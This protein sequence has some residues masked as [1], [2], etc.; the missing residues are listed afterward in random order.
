M[1]APATTKVNVATITAQSGFGTSAYILQHTLHA[2]SPPQGSSRSP[3]P[4]ESFNGDEGT[5]TPDTQ[6][7]KTYILESLLRERRRPMIELCKNLKRQCH[8][9]DHDH[10]QLQEQ[11]GDLVCRHE[12]LEV[13]C[14]VMENQ[15]REMRQDH[16]T[17]K[18]EHGLLNHQYHGLQT[19]YRYLEDE[20]RVQGEKLKRSAEDNLEMCAAYE[21]MEAEHTEE[22]E[23]AKKE[24]ATSK[25]AQLTA[26]AESQVLREMSEA[27]FMEAAQVKKEMELKETLWVE[28][29][30][31]LVKQH[32]QELEKAQEQC[33]KEKLELMQAAQNNRYALEKEVVSLG[34]LADAYRSETQDVAHRHK[35]QIE[36]LTS[37]KMVLIQQVD[38]LQS[39]LEEKMITLPALNNI[40]AQIFNLFSELQTVKKNRAVLLR[41]NEGLLDNAH[42]DQDHINKVWTD[43]RNELAKSSSLASKVA[44]LTAIVKDKHEVICGLI[45]TKEQITF[46]AG[47]ESTTSEIDRKAVYDIRS[48]EFDD[49]ARAH[50]RRN[51]ILDALK[52]KQVEYQALEE[53]TS[54]VENENFRLLCND[55]DHVTRFIEAKQRCEAVEGDLEEVEE[56]RDF[57]RR[58]LEGSADAKGKAIAAFVSK[59]QASNYE[60]RNE[61]WRFQE[62]QEQ[63]EAAVRDKIKKL[64]KRVRS[65]EDEADRCSS[66]YYHE[67]LTT[68]KRLHDRIQELSNQLGLDYYQESSHPYN[69]FVAD[70]NALR[71]AYAIGGYHPDMP[72]EVLE[73]DYF[74]GTIPATVEALRKLRPLGWGPIWELGKVWLTPTVHSYTEEDA[75]ERIQAMNEVERT[76]H[77]QDLGFAVA[78]NHEKLKDLAL[79]DSVQELVAEAK[80]KPVRHALVPSQG[81][82]IQSQFNHAYDNDSLVMRKKRATAT[83]PAPQA[84]D[85]RI[86]SYLKGICADAAKIE[87]EEYYTQEEFES[88]SVSLKDRYLE[89]VAEAN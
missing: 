18:D 66:A 12:H 13:R 21:E 23:S 20:H 58:R 37:E 74:A 16:R 87:E 10:R 52:V 19:R 89:M 7:S 88:L 63:C 72:S 73:P 47:S 4:T 27:K 86:P 54:K 84:D 5:E 14:S 32:K 79:Q 31:D 51:E 56:E 35:V 61:R 24:I 3:S 48:Q 28:K 29:S 46:L 85:S 44:E 76:R 34:L 39:A 59:L 8:T 30:W 57:L 41:D 68:T 36:E 55:D 75:L 45:K 82:T 38:M 17:L 43:W 60:L 53:K 71:V 80:P 67:A 49:V 77:R 15:Y 33:A 62:A 26:E 83:K 1:Y 64:E 2:R 50:S 6:H 65:A 22:L 42:K 40:N 81:K 9:L 11:H 78:P 70:R 69:K 25:R